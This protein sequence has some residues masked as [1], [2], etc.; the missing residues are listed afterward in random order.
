M[1]TLFIHL[2]P[3]Q[4]LRALG[5]AA[6]PADSPRAD[7]PRELDWMLSP[8]G[9]EP[10]A[11]GRSAPA[12]R[13]QADTVVL[14]VGESDVSW[15]RVELPKAGRQMRAALAGKLEESL[16]DEP[17][18][19][20]FALEADARPGDTAWVAI[21]SRPWLAEQLA[22]IEAEHVFV[23]RILPLSAPEAPARG[24]FHEV[25]T[26]GSATVALRWS[27]PEGVSS[28]PLAG[29]LA[30]QLF[31][32]ERV[33]ATHWTAAPAV[34]TAAERW[35]G[36]P[37]AVQTTAQR[38]LQAAQGSWNLRQFDLAPKARGTKA[39][40][41]FAREL[42]KKQWRPMHWGLA[43][44]IGLE[45]LGMNLR[46]WRLNHEL[47]AH[48]QAIEATLT[49]AFPQ[50]RAILDAPAQMQKQ[51]DLLR[52]NAGA[53]G[54][55][56]LESLLGAAATAW[57]ADR[58]PLDSLAYESGRLTI[59]AQGWTPPQIDAFR[60]QLRAEGWTLEASEG[61]LTLM[62]DRK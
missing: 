22:R 10:G 51:L 21:C 50:V 14:V 60:S 24:H 36:S 52:L 57:P 58:G 37:V 44:L 61:R 13:P 31:G 11:E 46:A 1:A 6:T 9:R 25:G 33:D 39:L 8:D 18:A 17:E 54:E 15:R 2:P 30:R 19:L 32:P 43:L 5:R 41:Q 28:L 12:A 47:K 20:H 49:T 26:N 55:Q 34:A 56:D 62:R 45:V 16:L 35:L 23:D 53:A 59:S 38:V 4:R 29:S 3:R 40:R 48:R 7:E 27:H 42:L